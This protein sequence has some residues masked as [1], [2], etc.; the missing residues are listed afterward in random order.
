MSTTNYIGK[1]TS[2]VD[3]PAKVTGAATYAAEFH[4]PNMAYGWVVS[5]PIAKG[6]ITKVH[7]DEVLAIPGVLEVFSHENVPSLAWFDRNYKDDVA[8]AARPSGP[9]TTTKSS[10]AS[11]PLPW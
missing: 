4:V 2:R 8:P 1:P 3:G 11:S 6:K 9:C 7:S 5:S 10:S